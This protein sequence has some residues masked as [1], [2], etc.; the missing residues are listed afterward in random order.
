MDMR[1]FGCMVDSFL[2]V[3]VDV[4]CSFDGVTSLGARTMTNGGL[5]AGGLLSCSGFKNFS[6]TLRIVWRKPPHGIST[7][8]TANIGN[9]L[10]R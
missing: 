10:L 1:G 2:C 3:L 9:A 7:Y 8:K 6:T 4:L 5:G